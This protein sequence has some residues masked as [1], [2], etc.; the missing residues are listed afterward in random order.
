MWCFPLQER[1]LTL[2]PEPYCTCLFHTPYLQ[3]STRAGP[4]KSKPELPTEVTMVNLLVATLF[5]LRSCA[6]PLEVNRVIHQSSR[7]ER[8][9]LNALRA[10]TSLYKF[11]SAQHQAD[12]ARLSREKS[13][14]GP[15]PGL[16]KNPGAR[17][18]STGQNISDHHHACHRDRHVRRDPLHLQGY[19]AHDQARS[20]R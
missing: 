1:A 2:A 16:V 4:E 7:N 13:D 19:N 11:S 9:H 6:N 14:T 17:L 10:L 15:A 3:A 12:L 18:R 20:I 5:S 8:L